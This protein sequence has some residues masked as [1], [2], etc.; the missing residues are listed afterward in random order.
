MVLLSRG[1]NGDNGHVADGLGS[2]NRTGIHIDS[3]YDADKWRKYGTE[4]KEFVFKLHRA[5]NR[6]WEMRISRSMRNSG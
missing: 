5:I 1:N 6:I 3:N 4:R 2:G